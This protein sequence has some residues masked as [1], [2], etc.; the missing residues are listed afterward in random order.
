MKETRFAFLAAL[1]L[2]SLV[3]A[4]WEIPYLFAGVPQGHELEMAQIDQQEHNLDG[5][6][7]DTV[8]T[9]G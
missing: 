3:A 7:L 9:D 8:L 1:A 2:V 6:D 4:R 5:G